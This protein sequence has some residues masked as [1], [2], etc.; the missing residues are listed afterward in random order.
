MN[1]NNS[2]SNGKNNNVKNVLHEEAQ[3]PALERQ[4]C[5]QLVM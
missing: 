2:S 4:L 5:L 3:V 1:K